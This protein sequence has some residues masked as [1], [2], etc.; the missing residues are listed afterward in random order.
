MT[1]AGGREG[2]ADG[3]PPG[4]SAGDR[5]GSADGISRGAASVRSGDQGVAIGGQAKKSVI[6]DRSSYTDNR[7]FHLHGGVAPL[8]AALTLAALALRPSWGNPL[9]RAAGVIAVVLAVATAVTLIRR[10]PSPERIPPGSAAETTA[11][12]SALRTAERERV[13][14]DLRLRNIGVSTIAVPWEQESGPTSASETAPP[15]DEGDVTGLFRIWESGPVTRLLLSGPVGSGKSVAL[16]LLAQKLLDSSDPGRP[17][18]VLLPL[19]GWD[20]RTPVYEWVA[21]QLAERHPEIVGAE[22]RVTVGELLRALDRDGLIVPF[23]DTFDELAPARRTAFVDA[24][25]HAVDASGSYVL[26]S[27]GT[28]LA[29]AERSAGRFRGSVTLRLRPLDASHFRSFLTDFDQG[30][31]W[32]PL[33]TAMGAGEAPAATAAFRTPLM[34]WLGLRVFAGGRDPLEL[35]DRTVFPRAEDVRGHLLSSLVRAVY[36]HPAN[37]SAPAA[38]WTVRQAERTLRFLAARTER[39]DHAIRWWLMH[40]GSQLQLTLVYGL[41]AT[42]VAWLTAGVSPTAATGLVL[43]GLWGVLTGAG[44]TGGYT[45]QR[46]SELERRQVHR[47]GFRADA[48]LPMVLSRIARLTPLLLGAAAAVWAVCGTLEP[49]GVGTPGAAW[50]LGARGCA[51]AVA[52]GLFGGVCAGMSLRRITRLEVGTAPSQASGP[53]SL[54]TRDRRASAGAAF[55]FGIVVALAVVGPWWLATGEFAPVAFLTA[56]ALAGAVVGPPLFTAWPVFHATH[57][58]LA[59]RGHLPARYSAFLDGARSGGI[60]R[61]DGVTY[62]FRHELLRQSLLVSADTSASAGRADGATSPTS[63]PR[64]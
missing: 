42:A 8:L 32:R 51:V 61:E 34:Q 38:G 47:S 40:R 54:L 12:L 35:A 10:R 25:N 22:S 48:D 64:A 37:L 30:A 43:G 15:P 2:P 55:C 16:T 28:E 9:G 1:A 56:A 50:L 63:A 23:F 39:G 20:G 62:R 49:P 14:K 59:V 3:V 24:L 18:P 17:I 57:L 31:R 44:F 46:I 5:E 36:E 45:L 13:E 60:L 58:V 29:E 6:G 27:W 53:A 11:W 41:L 4:D 7:Q 19:N 21:R 52:G 33:L 26:A